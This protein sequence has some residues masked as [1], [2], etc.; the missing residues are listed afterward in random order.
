MTFAFATLIG[1]NV[2]PFSVPSHVEYSS[3]LHTVSLMEA[4]IYVHVCV[5]GV[6]GCVYFMYKKYLII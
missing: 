4:A 1:T 6:G 3:R 2:S 5:C